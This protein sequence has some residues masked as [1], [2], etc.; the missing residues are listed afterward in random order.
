MYRI[1][2]VKNVEVNVWNVILVDLGI[3]MFYN[4]FILLFFNILEVM[5]IIFKMCFRFNGIN[6]KEFILIL[7]IKCGLIV[8]YKIIIIFLCIVFVV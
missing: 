1:C 2:I 3:V 5:W 6:L 4:I 7:C 8:F